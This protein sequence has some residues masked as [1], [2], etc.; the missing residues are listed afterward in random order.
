MTGLHDGEFCSAESN[1]F[2]HNS[3]H[4]MARLPIRLLSRNLTSALS[5]EYVQARSDAILHPE[6]FWSEQAKAISW[7]KPFSKVRCHLFSAH[8][9]GVK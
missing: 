1:K 7:N 9:K 2:I 3:S 5:A 6:A 4:L 8:M